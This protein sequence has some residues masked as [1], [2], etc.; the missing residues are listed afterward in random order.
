[1][2]ENQIESQKNEGS[3]QDNYEID[4]GKIKE[5]LD[6]DFNCVGIDFFKHGKYHFVKAYEKNERIIHYRYFNINNSNKIK[7]VDDNEIL[8]YFRKKYEPTLD[9]E[10]NKTKKKKRK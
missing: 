2:E 4:I 3:Q 5:L 8:N 1:M 6:K 9:I 7:E 10:I